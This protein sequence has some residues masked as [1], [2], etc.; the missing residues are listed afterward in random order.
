MRNVFIVSAARTPIGKYGGSLMGIP[1]PELG[2][3][4]VKEAVKRAGIGP[5]A[6]EEVIMG[7]VLQAGLGQNPARQV[8]LKAGIPIDVPAM[9][10]NKVCGSGLKSVIL[11]TQ[12]IM[13][14]D[15]DIVAAGGMENMSR[16]PYLLNDARWGYRMND[17]RLIDVMVYDGLTDVFNQY[18]M[19]ITA[20]NLAEK[21]GISREEQDRFALDS[22]Q[23][24]EK[25]QK[26]GKFDDEIVPVV[27]PQKKGEPLVFDKDEHIRYGTTYEALAKLKPAFKE[28]G[29]VTAGNSS[30]INDGA[31]AVIL[32]SEDKVKSL[33]LKPLAR[34]VS[35]GVAAV[36]PAIMGIA[37]VNAI[38]KALQKAGLKIEDLDLIELNEAF[39]VQS[40]AVINELEL[41]ADRV[42]VNGGAIALGHPIGA[43][44]CRILVTLLYE[45]Q[46]RNS[47]YGLAS[48]CIGGGQACALIVEREV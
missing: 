24:A 36:E 31:A 22:Q 10:I 14:G 47:R 7:N 19:G 46:R 34:I 11:G 42:N 48:L 15:A 2:A 40:L 30:G 1:A 27:I 12:A 9:T 21:Y 37:P 45:M 33:G 41:P 29:T 23:K 32:S 20:E 17:G 13:I 6:V 5:K 16:A 18:H 8:S 28:G 38:K 4:A 3:I 25:A 39:A 44:G 35:Y 43:S 26:E